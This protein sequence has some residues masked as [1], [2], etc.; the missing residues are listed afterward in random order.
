MQHSAD[1]L[2]AR[3]TIDPAVCGGRPCIRGLRVRVSDVL[4]LLG[5]GQ[6]PD[7]I[8]TD[9][10]YVERPDIAAALLYASRSVDHPVLWA[11]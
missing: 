11:S 2:L 7:E 5:A 3:I 1:D 4:D 9:Y 6:S 8:L 10:P